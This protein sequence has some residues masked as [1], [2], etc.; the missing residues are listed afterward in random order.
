MNFILASASASRKQIL[1]AAGVPFTAI[2]SAVDEDRIKDE[3]LSSGRAL[4]NIAGALAEAKALAIS[5]AHPTDLV[6]GADQT[7]LFEGELISKCQDLAAARALLAR[8]RGKAHVLAGGLALARGGKVLWRHDETSKLTMR[9]FSNAFLDAYLA[10]E[11]EGILGCVG[12][13]KFEGLG[14]Q[15]FAAV[16]GDYFSILGLPLQPLL[17]EL[18]RQGVIAT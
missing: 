14:S 7:L 12:C 9:E 2:P 15:L 8:L 5:N 16:E 17:S 6:L 4:S 10:H 11:G 18:R 1:T 13:Y 3:L